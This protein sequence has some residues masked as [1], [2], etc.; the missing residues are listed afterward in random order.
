[1]HNACG[2]PWTIAF[3]A[4][5]LLFTRMSSAAEPRQITLDFRQIKG[6]RDT[7]YKFCVG[8]ERA[9]VMLREINQKQLAL[10][11]QELGFQYIRF[12]GIFH[13]DMEA[14]R[15]HD[16]EPV[17]DWS[18]I[19]ALYDSF[20]KIGLKPFIEMSFMPRDLASGH[21]TV[22]WWNGNITP[23]RDFGKWADF[24]EAFA[25]HLT[26]RY[27]KDE[28]RQWYF[29]VWNEPNLKDFWSSDQ[30]TYFHLY[31]VTVAAIKKVDPE[32]RVG[33]PATAG[34]AWIPETIQHC[35]DQHIPLDFISTHTYAVTGF[36]D[37]DGKAVNRLSTDYNSIAHDVQHVRREI[38]SS[39]MPGLP[40]HFTEW[41]SSYSPR[42][43]VHDTYLNATFILDRL[44][45]CQG[46]L[47]SMS[48]WTYSDLFEEAGPPPAPFHGGFGLLNRE[49]IRKASFFAYKYLNELGDQEL[50]NTDAQ[51]WA[52]RHENRAAIL[53]WDHT[54]PNQDQPDQ[55]YYLKKHPPAA[56]APMPVKIIGLPPG[57]YSLE[58][59]RTGYESNDAYSAYIDMGRPT[60]LSPEQLRILQQLSADQAEQS[61]TVTIS[62]G[63]DFHRSIPLRQ[64]DIVLLMLDPAR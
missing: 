41:N 48:Y 60:K 53:V 52:T 37:A 42:D 51:S 27:G 1:M 57:R 5:V 39:A 20:H 43:P 46:Q 4:A 54:L 58:I 16:G 12:H 29:E 64:N 22:F 59:H 63:E 33:G 3:F 38:E 2:L 8:S 26:D 24:I 44:K 30:T 40:L 55:V 11:H 34:I 6:P 21:K 25:Q 23:P 13:D 35:H 7:F 62:P 61:E 45:K 50:Q 49:G 19:D 9:G 31:D 14:Y 10:A 32:Y 15:E 18:R 28:V 36:F 56:L 47:Q 17:Y